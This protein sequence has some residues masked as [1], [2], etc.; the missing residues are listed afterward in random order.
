M[1]VVTLELLDLVGEEVGVCL[2]HT[3]VAKHQSGVTVT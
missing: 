1:V 2:D 3:G